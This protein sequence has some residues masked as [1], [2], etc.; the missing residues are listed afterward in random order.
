[1]TLFY[2]TMQVCSR[3]VEC[4]LAGQV[5]GSKAS[6][7]GLAGQVGSRVVVC[8]IITNGPLFVFP[9]HVYTKLWVVLF[10]LL[11]T[12]RMCLLILVSD[13][14]YSMFRTYLNAVVTFLGYC[15]NMIVQ[16]SEYYQNM[17]CGIFLVSVIFSKLPSVDI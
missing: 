6:G 7:C 5:C 2:T 4:R 3:V 16:F 15:K 13:C 12:S 1:M 10:T 14:S 8:C 17:V 9:V 11:T